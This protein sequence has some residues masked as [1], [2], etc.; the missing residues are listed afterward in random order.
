LLAFTHEITINH[1]SAYTGTQSGDVLVPYADDPFLLTFARQ[2]CDNLGNHVSLGHDPQAL[3]FDSLLGRVASVE[4]WCARILYECVACDKP[5]AL[6]LYLQLRHAAL[7]IWWKVCSAQ[8]W[9]LRIALEPSHLLFS[10]QSKQCPEK[11]CIMPWIIRTPRRYSNGE[12][13]KSMRSRTV[14]EDQPLLL[15]HFMEAVRVYINTV[16]RQGEHRDPQI[17]SSIDTLSPV[18]VPWEEIEVDR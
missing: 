16:L 8:I 6:T 2:F 13:Q 15:H 1:N 17:A 3:A 18:L 7:S 10:L 11:T 5:A 12:L 9:S 4:H 14:T